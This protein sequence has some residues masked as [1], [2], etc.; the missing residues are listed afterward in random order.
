MNKILAR[1]DYQTGKRN[2]KLPRFN[3]PGWLR[4]GNYCSADDGKGRVMHLT[5][6]G[7]FSIYRA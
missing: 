6:G 7:L 5:S 4:A 1:Y 3:R 2:K